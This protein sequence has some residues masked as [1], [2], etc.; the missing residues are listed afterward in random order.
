MAERPF[1]L[2]FS[3]LVVDT[4]PRCCLALPAGFA[5]SASANIESPVFATTPQALLD[6]FKAAGLAEARTELVREG[7]GQIELVQRS[8]LFKF[9]D[10]ITAAAVSVE[11]GA[12]L[13]VYS[14]A[15]IGY[16][17]LGVNTKRVNRW[18]S[19]TN[20]QF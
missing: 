16:S 13:C 18:L 4:R 10:Y 15:V 14:R 19:A 5:S 3:S 1:P 9:P 6:A 17:D 8:A 20:A 2:E 12:A 7:E 11:G